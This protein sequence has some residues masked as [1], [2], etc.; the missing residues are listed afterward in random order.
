MEAVHR[1]KP[2][3]PDYKTGNY[4]APYLSLFSLQTE[5]R[6]I[7]IY[8]EDYPHGYCLYAINIGQTQEGVYP[9]V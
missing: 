3:Q 8:Q 5:D 6:G 9:E 4:A 1:L 2:F 7:G